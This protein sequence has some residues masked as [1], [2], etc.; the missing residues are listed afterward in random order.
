MGRPLLDINPDEVRK[1]AELGCRTEEIAD[2]FGCSH[3][4]I[5]KRFAS[6]LVKGRAKI[7]ITLRRSQIQLAMKGNATLLIW[8]GKQMLGQVE[9][10]QIDIT[11]IDDNTFMQEAQRR[12]KQAEQLVDIADNVSAKRDA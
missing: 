8:L 12:L 1:L 9:R 2:F 5:N 4:T 6:E 7:A 11:K 10:T 3:D